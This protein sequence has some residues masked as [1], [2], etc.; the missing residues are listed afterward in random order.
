MMNCKQ[1]TRLLSDAQERKLT[2]KEK[3][4]LTMHTAMC[5]ACRNFGKQMESIRHISLDYVRGNNSKDENE[6]DE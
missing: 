5:S 2:L 6:F 4:T 3:T 1:A